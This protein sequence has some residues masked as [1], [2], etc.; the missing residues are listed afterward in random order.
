MS[1]GH[2]IYACEECG[3]VRSECP[4]GP[5]VCGRTGTFLTRI[6][7]DCPHCGAELQAGS[8]GQACACGWV[9]WREPS[10]SRFEG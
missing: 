9:S 7:Y 3:R 6:W 8:V 10:P 1:A 4:A 5:C 2:W